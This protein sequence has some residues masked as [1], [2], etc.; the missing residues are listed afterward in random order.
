MRNILVI[1]LSALGDFV[2]SIGAMQAIRTH[3]GGDRITLLTTAPFAR[4]AEASGCFDRVWIDERP[5]LTRP[6]AWLRLARKLRQAK[7]DRVYDLQRAQR[8]GWY[9]HLAGRPEWFGKVAGC[10]HRYLPPAGKALHATEREAGQL[11]LAGI[12][13]IAPPD[14]SFIESDIGRFAL[15]RDYALL[16]PGCAPH[17]PGKRWPAGS[18]GELAAALAARGITPVLIGGPAER[19]EMAIIAKACPGAKNLCGETEL[20]DL[21]PLA[22]GARVAIGNDTGPTHLIA[23]AGCPT[24]ALF[25]QDSHPVTSR[26]PW[27]WVRVL[28]EARLADLPVAAVA[29]AAA[30]IERRPGD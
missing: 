9:F 6:L 4:L 21:A 5:P 7:F 11:A 2:L 15:P 24:V 25:S 20:F 14:L 3:H 8:T 26:P 28:H 18:Y 30:E 23:A 19:Q 29:Q 13:R 27:P 22:R 10:S 1:K 16:M 12:E 17:R